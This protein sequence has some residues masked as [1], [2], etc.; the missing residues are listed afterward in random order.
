MELV[1]R[2]RHRSRRLSKPRSRIIRNPQG[3]LHRTLSPK[4]RILEAVRD[5][6]GE[7]SAQLID[8]LKKSDMASE[9]E[10]LLADTGWLPE[11]LRTP[12]IDVGGEPAAETTEAEEELSV[13]AAERRHGCASGENARV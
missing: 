9:A 5:A 10:R 11:P 6:K 12:A 1:A 8:H 7:R 3:G 13:W 4:A 2:D